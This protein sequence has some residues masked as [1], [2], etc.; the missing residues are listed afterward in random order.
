MKI[1]TWW[2][3]ALA[4]LLLL[5][6]S[7]NEQHIGPVHSVMLTQPQGGE[8]TDVKTLAGSIEEAREISVAFK[9]PGQLASI[10][11]HEGDYVRAGQLIAALDDKDIRL[12]LQATQIQYEQ[13]K[14]EVE[15]LSRLQ[16]SSSISG[17][18][19]DKATSG[20]A[21]LEVA[22]RGYQNKLS[23]AKLYAP[24]SGYV[25][26]VNF[27]AAEMVNAGTPVITLLDTR[28]MEV[29]CDIPAS[30]YM[31]RERIS[32]IHCSGRFSEGEDIPLTLI[33]ISPKADANQLYRMRLALSDCP[34][35]TACGQNVQ[36][37]VSLEQGAQSSTLT[38]PMASV[39][40]EGGKD[41]VMLFQAKDSTVTRHVVT[42]DGAVDD[43]MVVVKQGLTGS[44][45]IVK[46]GASRLSDGERV[47]VIQDKKK[48][49]DA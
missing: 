25:Q 23:Y 49:A 39:I 38:V 14:R 21:Q 36:V 35:E 16:Q 13:V 7:G 10:A 45:S 3:G 8:T 30:L 34:H 28:Q 40:H 42:L 27:E 15:R 47:R 37:R 18:D 11:V 31:A 5:A 6:C 1:R 19:Y 32:S 22:L 46:A 12:E 26:S 33:S 4:S 44:E 20:L 48:Q 2:Y 17:N 9:V 29:V 24:A 43:G 41:Y